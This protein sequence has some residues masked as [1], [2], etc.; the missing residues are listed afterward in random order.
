[1]CCGYYVYVYSHLGALSPGVIYSQVCKIYNHL[2]GVRVVRFPASRASVGDLRRI[3]FIKDYNGRAG[4]IC[5]ILPP[6][7]F[8][9]CLLFQGV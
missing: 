3:V 9:L 2:A 8:A 4:V 1:M 7:S 5:A 6:L